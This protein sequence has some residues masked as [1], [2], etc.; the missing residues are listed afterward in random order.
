MRLSREQIRGPVLALALLMVP[1]GLFLG[2][3]VEPA[4][5]AYR[6]NQAEIVGLRERIEGF[7]RSAADLE[8]LE[9]HLEMLRKQHSASRYTLSQES[10]TLAA[11]SLQ[12]RVKELVNRHGG[13][14]VSTRVLPLQQQQEF[15]RVGVNVQMRGSVDALR[16]ILYELET[17][18]PMLIVDDFLIQAIDG[19]FRRRRQPGEE[20]PPGILNLRFDLAGF[21][22]KEAAS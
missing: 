8:V 6:D 16:N 2:L 15:T 21:I 10:E 12:E 14:L 11:A 5:R 7:R 20:E 3:V 9:R 1:V 19:Q 17:G 13:E 22:R 18:E 4:W